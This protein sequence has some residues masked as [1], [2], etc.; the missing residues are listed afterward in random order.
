MRGLDERVNGDGGK[1]ISVLMS[2]GKIKSSNLRKRIS[3]V[4]SEV[5]MENDPRTMPSLRTLWGV[6]I[7]IKDRK[8]V[9]LNLRTWTILILD[10]DFKDFCF[11]LLYGRLYLNLAISHFSETAPGCTFCTIKKGRELRSRGIIIGT[12][13]YEMEIVQVEPETIDHLFWS[14]SEVKGVIKNFINMMGGTVGEKV[15]VIKYW[16]GCELEYNVDSMLSILVVR[17]VQY[18]IYRCRIRRR[19]PLLANIRDDVG[20]LVAQL[21]KRAKGRG[22]LQRLQL[23]CQ[24]ML[25]RH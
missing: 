7:D 18:A 1:N 10:P 17:F 14:C 22:G 16:E 25:E 6:R 11:R 9:E 3:G 24:Q 12:Q 23:T 2:R 20:A 13:Q 8:Y 19:L 5:F 4:D 15:S 21:N